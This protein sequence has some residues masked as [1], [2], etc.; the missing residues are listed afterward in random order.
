[1]ERKNAP[2][3]VRAESTQCPPT[4]LFWKNSLFF[5]KFFVICGNF[6][7]TDLKWPIRVHKN[8]ISASSRESALMLMRVYG[9]S[10]YQVDGKCSCVVRSVQFVTGWR[11]ESIFCEKNL[12]QFFLLLF[13]HQTALHFNLIDIPP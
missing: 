9:N 6:S 7:K 1:M 11:I 13:A 3:A 10:Q 12:P 8:V 5:V 4:N 2:H